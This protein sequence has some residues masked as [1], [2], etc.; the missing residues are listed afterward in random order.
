MPFNML[1][2]VSQIYRQTADE[3][4]A[5]L[6]AG[7]P[8][9]T[10]EE[11]ELDIINLLAS[12]IA[13][14]NDEIEKGSKIKTHLSMPPY[15]T[16]RV[17]AALWPVYK[18]PCAG[19]E[20][21]PAHDL[22]GVYQ[23]EGPDEGIYLTSDFA[24]QRLF[25]QFN[26][27]ATTRDF[28]EFKAVL[29]ETAERRMPCRDRDLIAVNNGIFDYQSKQL[30]AFSPDLVFLAKSRV[31]Y[32]PSAVNPIIH[33]NDDGTDWDVE[34]W[35]S[36]LSDDPEIVKLLWEILGAIIR[37]NVSWN[38]AAFFYSETGNNGKGTLCKLMQN[39]CG[40]GTYCSISLADFGKEFMLEPLMRASAVIVDEN[41]V[42]EYVDRC[43]N[44][45]A[46]I[47]GDVIYINRKYEKP[48]SFLFRGFMVQCLNE[49][50]RVKDKSD[51]LYRR[52][53]FVPFSKCFTGMERRYIKD[54]YLSRHE[55]L[56][57][58]LWKILNMDYYELSNPATCQ[59]VMDAY[60]QYN[61]PL[62]QFA[63][64]IFPQLAWDM[65]PLAYLFDL[66]SAWFK[67]CYPGG[68]PLGKQKFNMSIFQ[69]QSE[70]PGW[71]CPGL[72]TAKRPGNDMSKPEPLSLEYNLT[73]WLNFAC[74]DSRS[75]H[76]TVP[77]VKSNYKGYFIR[78]NNSPASTA[79]PKTA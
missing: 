11:I 64:E 12:K 75:P 52:M 76:Y 34:S 59:D 32:V 21:D 47:T 51:S 61:D 16:A 25:R 4:L 15:I 53:L 44:L 7:T 50:P 36:E 63:D 66:Y 10:P 45:K 49:L 65:V 26:H 54:D 77:V 58:V 19:A 13:A 41:N 43:A 40:P 38:K 17:I 27:A 31:N 42:G 23:E 5:A 18:I 14:L 55:V 69:M 72:G 37:P 22:I 29:A 46:V 68:H 57:Y 3:Y 6:Q 74:P 78:V 71:M 2:T 1:T 20:T 73:N 35:L 56:E 62:R 24:L 39:L 70:I 9:P 60:R 48:L 33:N 67:R 30:Q 79:A 28:K 8:R